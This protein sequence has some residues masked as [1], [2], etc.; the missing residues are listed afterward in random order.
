[1]LCRRERVILT[2]NLWVEAWLVNGV[3]GHVEDIHY[4]LGFKSHELLVLA[5]VVFEKYTSI[6]F[7]INCL[8]IV[9]ITPVVRG[10][11]KYMPLRMAWP[12]SINKSQGMTLQ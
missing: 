2:C 3:L 12:F 1:M 7:D 4:M 11:L 8:N 6:T 9:L 10:S 5:T